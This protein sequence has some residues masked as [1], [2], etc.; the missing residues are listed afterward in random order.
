MNRII[1]VTL[2]GIGLLGILFL[3]CIIGRQVERSNWEAQEMQK[4]SIST[5]AVVN[6]DDG[7][8]VG[9]KRVNYAS[10]LMNFPSEYFTVT[11]LIDAQSGIENGLYAAYIVI[12]ETFSASVTSLENEPRK[13]NLEYRYNS[14]LDEETEIRAINDVNAF[15]ISLN[16]NIA[17]MY[18]DAILDEFHRIQD[19]ADTILTNDN[20]ELEQ[21]E[22]VNAEQLIAA[23]K[24]I[25]EV[26]VD[27]DIPLIKLNSY[28]KQNNGFLKSLLSGYSEALQKGKDEYAAIQQKNAEVEKAA[29]NFFSM[30]E[31]VISDTVD[32]Q[33]KILEAA[34]KN[35]EGEI[36][37]YNQNTDEKKQ[38][39]ENIIWSIADAQLEADQQ[40]ANEQLQ[41]ILQDINGNSSDLQAFDMDN[42]IDL[43]N[44]E[45]DAPDDNTPN[46]N[47]SDNQG[48]EGDGGMGTGGDEHTI[49]LSRAE[50]D[51]INDRINE[52]MG[53]FRLE[54]EAEKLDNV[55]QTQFV[56][57]MLNENQFQMN[58]LSDTEEI[59]RKQIKE[60]E[61]T[62]VHYDPL[63]YV[64]QAN[65][66]TYLDRIEINTEDMVNAV[67]QN[68][69]EYISYAAKVDAAAAENMTKLK[70][71]L[72]R[73]GTKTAS[74]VKDCISDLVLS[75]EKVNGKNVGILE[76]FTG[77]LPY[78]RVGNQENM[79]VYDYIINPIV[80]RNTGERPVVQITGQEKPRISIREIMII[81]LGIG[82]MVSLAWAVINFQ[83]QY[84]RG[85]EES[86]YLM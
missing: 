45:A 40:S 73:A 11:G 33:S 47:P 10:Q 28:I 64:E 50:A 39:I 67:E 35:L 19:D 55:I 86:D 81:I 72:S 52:V 66:N 77:L 63:K 34:K 12:P 74:N 65:L 60:Y 84:M 37:L 44:E 6:M 75:R 59:L 70:K 25:N 7:V 9:E 3:G 2:Y 4:E 43:G 68:N 61:N 46:D 31:S 80:S 56:E 62:L 16:S 69:A 15:V 42:S 53:L 49:L 76:G 14:K 8:M 79:E 26:T 38:E 30:Y 36:G 58:R 18:V 23:V 5:I 20:E 29:D 13:V 1:K 85:R 27:N 48:T 78:T 24:P 51:S 82:I 22:N 41:I 21:L 71:A 54:P 83:K 57:S 17:Y 32:E